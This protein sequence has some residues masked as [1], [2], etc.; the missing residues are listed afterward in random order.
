MLDNGLI[1]EI[2]DVEETSLLTLYTK[3][4]ESQSKDPILK[5]EYAEALGEKIDPLIKNSPLKMA[6]Q[7]YRRTIDHRLVVHLAIRSKKYDDYAKVFLQ[8]HPDGVI[9]NL[10]CGLDMRFF[11]VDNG[12]CV[13]FDIDLPGV[14]QL[15]RQLV[16]ET[17]RYHIIGQSILDH[18]W[19]A[20]VEKIGKPA[21][22]LMEGV[23]MYLPEADV[24]ELVLAIQKRFPESDLVCELTNRTWVEGFWGK[25]SAKKMQH[26]FSMGQDAGFQFGVDCP[27]ALEEWGDG[28][29]FIEQWFYMEDNHPKLGLMRVF[30][31]MAIFRNAQYTVYYRLH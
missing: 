14:I 9:V 24:R 2:S 27:E 30:R 15:K 10:G 6:K 22:F 18:K 1:S 26:R 7:L 11:R 16:G 17:D 8:S 21:I 20:S 31:N 29:E 28:I 12:N 5:D 4:I 19:M 3:A 13:Q 25:M 23:L